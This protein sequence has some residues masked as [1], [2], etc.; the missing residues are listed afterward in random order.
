MYGLPPNVFNAVEPQ[1]TGIT[2][3]DCAGCLEVQREGH[4]NLRF[5]CRVGHTMSVDEL[6]TGKEEKIES[7][8]WAGVRSLEELAA[9]LSD[10][11]AYARRHGRD[12]IGGPH[13]QRIAQSRAHA[14]RIRA[15]LA[16]KQPVELGGAGDDGAPSNQPPPAGRPSGS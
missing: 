12:Q 8:L 2:C 14:D 4:G 9:L 5:I 7:D 16:E 6:L 1:L 15:I 11:E 13:Q 3:P 10:L